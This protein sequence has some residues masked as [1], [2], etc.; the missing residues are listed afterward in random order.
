M[1]TPRYHFHCT[2]GHELVTD[3]RGK[4]IPSLAQV[5]LHAE[6]VACD[7]MV[8]GDLIDWSDW[9]VEIYDRKGRRIWLKAF[10]DVRDVAQAA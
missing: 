6:R 7:L 10:I 9:Q 4:R 1:P 5:R 8:A 2:D 3:I